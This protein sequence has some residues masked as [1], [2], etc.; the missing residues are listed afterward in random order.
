MAKNNSQRIKTKWN[1]YLIGY[2]ALIIFINLCLIGTII[3]A[4]AGPSKVYAIIYETAFLLVA[5][6]VPIV[7]EIS[8][9]SKQGKKSTENQQYISKEEYEK[10]LQQAK[11]CD[12]YAK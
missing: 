10:Y 8:L 12:I 7:M 2:V 9:T 5:I 6:V 4:E 11:N 3:F 1:K